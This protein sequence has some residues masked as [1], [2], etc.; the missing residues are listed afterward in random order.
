M[1]FDAESEPPILTPAITSATETRVILNSP[2]GS[3]FAAFLARPG[4]P[5]GTGVMVLPD[6][7][8]LSPFY[9]QLAVRVAEQGH[10]A[11]AID[12]FGRS[13]GTQPRDEKFPF[14]EHVIHITRKTLNE[15]MAAAA[16]FLR[17]PQGGGCERRLAMGFCFGGRQ[18]FLASA[19]EFSLNGVIGFYGA[20]GVYPNGSPGPTQRAAELAGPILA[21]FGG[22]DA[23]ISSE[24]ISAFGQALRNADIE[25]EIVI[26][27][28]APHSFFDIKYA[29]YSAACADAWRRVLDFIATERAL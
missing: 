19:P 7:R 29:E 4:S 15:D 14:M 13:A 24:D 5:S 20:P 10:T 22:A 11:L 2:D 28:G 17:L 9:E 26:Y 1:C 16:A 23:G 27:P 8:G 12:Y 21:I 18:A 6:L 3:R 25:H